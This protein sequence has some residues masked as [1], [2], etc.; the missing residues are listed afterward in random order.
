MFLNDCYAY[1]MFGPSG[2]TTEESNRML[3]DFLR[4]VY[5]VL[6][7]PFFVFVGVVMCPWLVI[8]LL[9]L[10]VLIWFFR[11]RTLESR[12]NERERIEYESRRI[13]EDFLRKRQLR[14]FERESRSRM[15]D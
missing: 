4:R 1:Y 8:P 10:S 11:K 13:L 12:K 5:L 14:E 7:V 9:V 2:Y 3:F 6:F 15:N